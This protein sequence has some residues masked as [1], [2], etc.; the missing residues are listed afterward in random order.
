MTAG[1]LSLQHT[2]C[3]ILTTPSH[4]VSWLATQSEHRVLGLLC[5]LDTTGYPVKVFNTADNRLTGP[6]PSFLVTGLTGMLA[7]MCS[8]DPTSCNIWVDV[9]GGDNKFS[10]PGQ[11]MISFKPN[12]TALQHD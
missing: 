7:H 11:L 5:R 9:D 2:T 8:E 12:L 1:T 10:C 4:H 3:G 6:F